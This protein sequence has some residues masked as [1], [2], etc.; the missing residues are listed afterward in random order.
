MSTPKSDP[1]HPFVSRG[2]LKLAHALDSFALDPSGLVCSDLGSSTG[3]FTDCLLQRGA[4]RVFSVDT[5]YGILAWKLRSDPRVTVL[6]RANALHVAIPDEVSQG[7]DLVVLDLGWTKQKHA[8][9]AALRWLGDHNQG[10][11]ISLIKPHYEAPQPTDRKRG[12]LIRL[13]EDEALAITQSIVE[14]E[15][16]RLGV[17]VLGLVRSP[18]LGGKSRTGKGHGN[19]EWLVHLMPNP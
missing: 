16:P 14:H 5:G 13:S 12:Q 17:R 9:P 11:I 8:I 18:I 4:S 10:H 19:C 7:V 6:E 2:G 15:L 3:G 1:V